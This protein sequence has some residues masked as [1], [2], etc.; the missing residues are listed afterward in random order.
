MPESAVC[1]D[2][3]QGSILPV[4]LL[5]EDEPRDAVTAIVVSQSCDIVHP[6]FEAEPFVEILIAQNAD[7]IDGAFTF[8][9]SA[10]RLDFSFDRDGAGHSVSC[11]INRRL[12]IDRRTLLDR[13]PVFNL[14]AR[15][16]LLIGRWISRRY[17]RVALPEALVQRIGSHRLAQIRKALKS[18]GA[19]LSYVFLDIDG[20]DELSNDQVYRLIIIG[21]VQMEVVRSPERFEQCSR[22]IARIRMILANCTGVELADARVLTEDQLSLSDLRSLRQWEFDSLSLGFDGQLDAT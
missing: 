21:T 1:L 17:N 16:T 14:P 7:V 9:K 3:Q 8:G 12:R 22:A 20:W 4:D 10:R 5:P 11:D 18:D 6:S 19:H 13:R 15:E 2:W